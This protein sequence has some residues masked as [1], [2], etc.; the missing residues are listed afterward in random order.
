MLYS[1]SDLC[2]NQWRHSVERLWL[3]GPRSPLSAHSEGKS[4]GGAANG[5]RFQPLCRPGVCCVAVATTDVDTLQP[6][7]GENINLQER[8][9]VDGADDLAVPENL[10]WARRD[11]L[12][13]SGGGRPARRCNRG[14][15]ESPPLFLPLRRFS[16]SL[17]APCGPID[18]KPSQNRVNY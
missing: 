8:K 14:T 1:A 3:P 7:L 16:S 13:G 6:K 5:R 18:S 10:S 2:F 15:P 4:G 11:L 12:S 17:V 9:C